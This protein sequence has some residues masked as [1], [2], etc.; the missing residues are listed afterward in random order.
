MPVVL[1]GGFW[2]IVAHGC[3][4]TF[5]GT[6]GNWRLFVGMVDPMSGSVTGEIR[7]NMAED[8]ST[9][10][11]RVVVT[12]ASGIIGSSVAS[13]LRTSL[14]SARIVGIDRYGG[15]STLDDFHLA[16]LA[17]ADPAELLVAADT[18]VHC[19]FNVRADAVT[20]EDGRLDLAIIRRILDG[21]TA[22][23]VNHVVIL[24]TTMV[25]GA[26]SDNPMP[27][28]EDAP[29]RPNREFAFAAH[30]AM[31]EQA[32]KDWAAHDDNRILSIV[33]PAVVV[34]EARRGGL[35]DLL[36][37]ASVIKSESGEAPAQYLHVD[38]LASAVAIV[39]AEQVGG[40]IN[41]APDSW[42][43]SDGLIALA[44]PKPRL[45]VPDWAARLLSAIRFRLGF[46]RTPPGI[47]PYV[48]HPWVVANDRIK[49]LGWEPTNSNEE[50]YVAGHDAGPL[51]N[52]NAKR[53]Q[54]LALGATAAVIVGG[55]VGIALLIR[56]SRS[57]KG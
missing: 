27:I 15:S 18:L 5:G 45:R 44:G 30:M 55:A 9:L 11:S 54:M 57:T 4:G 16:D 10:T 46:T 35:S 39:V 41:V 28:T 20:P 51:G 29:V 53:R 7:E 31:V 13:A 50:A 37:S 42:I 49:A 1:I 32:A 24:S 56:R 52:L 23:G 43:T 47:L 25:Y 3:E 22:A 8:E 38:D 33:R 12:G 21:A 14:P 34:S 6:S 36:S 2:E 40:P 19:L 26:W 48:T 17:T